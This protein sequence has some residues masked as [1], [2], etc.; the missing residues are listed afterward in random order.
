MSNNNIAKE[1][2]EEGMALQM[3]PDGRFNFDVIFLFFNGRK[4]PTISP[5]RGPAISWL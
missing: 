3:M 2:F 4:M 1:K 5:S